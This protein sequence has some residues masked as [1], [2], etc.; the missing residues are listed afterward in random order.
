ME[1]EQQPEEEFEQK[2]E[3]KTYRRIMFLFGK[4]MKYTCWFV[5]SVFFYHLYLVTKTDK[6]EEGLAASEFFLYYAIGAK[7]GY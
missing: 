1:E 5:A 4:M 7:E 2:A 3:F 6:P